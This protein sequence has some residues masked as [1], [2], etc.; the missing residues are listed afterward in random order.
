[1]VPMAVIRDQHTGPEAARLL[2]L[3]LAS[4]SVSP[5]LAPVFGG[6]LVQYTSWRLI[7]VVLIIICIAVWIMVARL[8]PETLPP[9]RRIPLRPAGVLVT[10]VRLLSTRRFVAPI[11]IAMCAQAVLLVFIAGAPFV[12]VT[13]HQVT[14]T[15]FGIVFALHAICII[16]TSQ[17]NAMM[18]RRFGARRLIGGGSL[19]LSVA[20]LAFVGLVMGGMTALWP[21]ALLTLCMFVCLGLIM[22]PAFLTAMEPFGSVAGAAAAIGSAVEFT[23]STSATFAMS[24][25]AD[26][27]ARPMAFA[28]AVAACGAFASWVYYARTD[29]AS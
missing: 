20:G 14:P 9:Q 29:Q 28:L 15:Q 1:V 11:M 12:F 21:L 10:Y 5:I 6:L 18:M 17:S 3:A 27:T 4:L 2:S 26:G 25:A 7:F 16:G 13:L 22:A 8:L 23:F 19:A 24:M